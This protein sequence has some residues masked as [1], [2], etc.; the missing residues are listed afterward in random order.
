MGLAKKDASARFGLR[1]Q[2]KNPQGHRFQ[3]LFRCHLEKWDWNDRNCWLKR[4]RRNQDW[5]E[6]GA[7][8][9][10]KRPWDNELSW[11]WLVLAALFFSVSQSGKLIIMCILSISPRP[12]LRSIFLRPP[13]SYVYLATF[14]LDWITIL[15]IEIIVDQKSRK[16]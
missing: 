6:I 1:N 12:C 10:Q 5:R 16:F 15:I 4:I 7:D 8:S 2:E 11:R 13:S 3:I 14:R 9:W